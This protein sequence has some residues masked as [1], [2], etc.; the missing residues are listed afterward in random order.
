MA[1]SLLLLAAAALFSL[2]SVNAAAVNLTHLVH[3][4]SR[5]YG[6]VD[7]YDS[8]NFFNDF[9]FWT[10]GDP[11]HGFVDYLSQ[12]DAWSAGIINLNNNQVY[13][14]VDYWTWMPPNGRASVRLTSNKAYTHGLF[15]ADI[16]HMPGD[17][18]GIW[19]AWWLVGGNWPSGG[20]ID[21]VEGVNL[22]GTDQITLH[23]SSGCTINTAGSQPGTTLLNSD[24]NSGDAHNGCGVTTSTPNAYGDSFNGAG[25]GVFAMQWASSGIYVWFFPRGQIPQDIQNE[26]PVTTNWGLP[27]VAFNGG[28]GCNIDSHFQNEQ[29]VFDTTF[30]GDWAGNSWNGKCATLADNCQD[31]VAQN[32]GAFGQ[33]Y[34]LINSV[35]VYQ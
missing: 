22:A 29:I 21:V 34:W 33:G 17:L 27:V 13:L 15:I 12:D 6:L 11:T 19:P 8:S 30:C 25:G 2:P 1:P 26:Q 32:G 3:L 18:C 35:K 28:S 7:R 16:Q 9:G 24:C 23:T 20:E 4:E 10:G 5:A 31:Y 14:G